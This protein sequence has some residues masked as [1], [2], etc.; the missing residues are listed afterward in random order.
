MIYFNSHNNISDNKL[1]KTKVILELSFCASKQTQFIIHR[2]KIKVIQTFIGFCTGAIR[3][4][5]SIHF[6]GAFIVLQS[7]NSQYLTVLET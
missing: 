2:H 3:D 6:L 7:R 1:T 5:F 4:V